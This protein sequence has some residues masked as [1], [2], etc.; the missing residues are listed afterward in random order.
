MN[1][2]L[3]KAPIPGRVVVAGLTRDAADYLPGVLSNLEKV[4]G[5]FDDAAYLLF[6]NDSKD[7]S[8]ELLRAWCETRPSARL[9]EID[10]L[11][12]ALPIRTIRLAFLRNAIIDLVRAEFADFDYLYLVDCDIAGHWPVDVTAFERAARFLAVDPGRAAIFPNNDGLYIDLWALRA[13]GW[14]PDDTWECVLE[15][16]LKLRVSD[17]DAF[18]AIF[19]PRAQQYIPR[20]SAPR[21]VQSAFGG[22]GLYK[23]ESVL[24]NPRRYVGHKA[25]VLP[26]NE[27]PREFGWQTCEHVS[28]NQ[29]FGALGQSLYIMPDWI[30]QSTPAQSFPPS[31]FRMMVFELKSLGKA[32]DWK[33]Q[34]QR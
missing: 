23:I 3:K 2:A 11:A 8:K 21:Q 32:P 16:M 12:E 29:G 14:C 31:G 20:G 22:A 6:E 5:Q 17:E 19:V 13:E 24:K 9:F 30:N 33:P 34:F 7:G 28:F 15:Y 26:T 10:G 18:K 25:K 27:G 4:G 1:R